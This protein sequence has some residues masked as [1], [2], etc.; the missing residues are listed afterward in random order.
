MFLKRRVGES[1]FGG[2]IKI[3]KMDVITPNHPSYIDHFSI[4]THGF[5]H[6]QR[7]RFLGTTR[8]VPVVVVEEHHEVRAGKLKNEHFR[9][10]WQ[11]V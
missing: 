7:H 6:F 11:V 5:H 1:S 2:L 9:V 4:E 10:A 3:H 8:R